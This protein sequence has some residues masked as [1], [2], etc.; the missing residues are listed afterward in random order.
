[1]KTI[2]V[3]T[4]PSELY[5]FQGR[6]EAEG[7]PSFIGNENLLGVQ[8]FYSH[9][10]GG[11]TLEVNDADF[12]SA[13]L[14]LAEIEANEFDLQNSEEFLRTEE[15]LQLK[16]ALRQNKE[17]T[18]P[19]LLAKVE[20]T[21]LN[22]EEVLEIM[23]SE[24][25]DGKDTPSGKGF[26]KSLF[27]GTLGCFFRPKTT[28]FYLESDLISHKRN[29]AHHPKVKCPYCG[30]ENTAFGYSAKV[31]QGPVEFIVSL[32]FTIVFYLA[33]P[34]PSFRKRYHCFNCGNEFKIDRKE[35]RGR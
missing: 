7:I 18:M 14:I 33:A 26:W 32:L 23:Q 4:Y 16:E 8:P 1:L 3:A 13:Q 35:V 24:Q 19:E 10:V 15:E 22:E 9:A 20:I 2:K 17:L 11:A 29:A 28:V 5:V 27:D 6:L 34:F 30:S 12:E 21:Y 25:K 31:R